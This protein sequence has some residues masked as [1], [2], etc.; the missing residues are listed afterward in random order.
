MNNIHATPLSIISSVPG[1][2]IVPVTILA[3]SD[4]NANNINS[5][6]NLNFGYY[7]NATTPF[8]FTNGIVAQMRR[9]AYN[10][11]TDYLSLTSPTGTPSFFGS[12]V[13]K[14]F[15]ISGEPLQAFTS[16]CFNHLDLTI[17]YIIV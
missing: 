6:S 4:H 1:K 7:I 3:L 13:G 16:N 15:G 10:Y 5:R 14:P 8:S 12:A 9:F 2:T 17:T 11:S